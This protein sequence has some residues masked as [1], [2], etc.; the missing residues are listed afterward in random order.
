MRVGH[1]GERQLLVDLHG[2]RA[3]RVRSKQVGRTSTQL[4]CRR[5]IVRKVRARKV[6]RP[7]FGKLERL[8]RRD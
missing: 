7:R 3:G 5:N 8:D 6:Y 2:E 1:F 4:G